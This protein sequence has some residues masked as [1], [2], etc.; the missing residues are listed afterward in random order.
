MRRLTVLMPVPA[1]LV[2]VPGGVLTGSKRVL[3]A[4]P[5]IVALEV[6][7]EASKLYKWTDDFKI[8]SPDSFST[9]NA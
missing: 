2:L 9:Q 8:T 5:P 3:F 6:L 4:I 1:V 7:D